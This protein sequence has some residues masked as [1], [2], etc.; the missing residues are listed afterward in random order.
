MG[1]L[2][3]LTRDP[4]AFIVLAVILLYSIIAH[5]VAHGWTARLFGDHTAEEEGRLTANPVPHIDPIGLLMLFFAG[6]GWAKPVPV[7]Y[8]YLRRS[9]GAFIAVSLAGVTANLL[10]AF[11]AALLLQSET[12]RSLPALPLALVVAVKINVVLA[13]FNLIPLPPLDGSKV[14]A[15]FLP[16]EARIRFYRLERYGFFILI[17]LLFTG[18]LTPVINFM[19]GMVYGAIS[20]TL[21]LF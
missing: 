10:I 3:L 6:F 16:V 11:T 8:A 17:A 7:D 14:L 1:L 4:A 15:E 12:V 9:R 13:A 20:L 21:R 2:S 18:V 5:E 19:Q